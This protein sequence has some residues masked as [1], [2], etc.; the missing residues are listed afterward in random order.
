[1]TALD[2][3][4]I[5]AAQNDD[6]AQNNAAQN[7]AA[8]NN[9]A[10]NNAAQNNAAQNNAAQN[11][12]AEPGVTARQWVRA[13]RETLL[14]SVLVLVSGYL[15]VVVL[16]WCVVGSAPRAELAWPA[17]L[18][19][20]VPGWL[21][22]F[23]IPL[24]IQGA[25]LTALPLLPT[26]LAA[27]LIA[28]AAAKVA[29]RARLRKPEQLLPVIV[30]MG[31]SHAL[32]GLSFALL[33]GTDGSPVRAAPWRAFAHCGAT[34]SLA[35][36]VGTVDRCGV[37]YLLWQRLSRPT[38]LALRAGVLAS[39]L[40]VAAGALVFL[41]AFCASLPEL[42]E[43]SAELGSVGAGLGA[44]LLAVLYVPNAVVGGWS[45]A[46]GAG[47]TMGETTFT[48]FGGAL[49]EPLPVLPL[50]GVLPA[51]PPPGW[52]AGVLAVPALVGVA[53]G[54]HC[55]R[56]TTREDGRMRVLA[57]AT[58]PVA[59][60][61]LSLA[62]LAGGGLGG[63]HGPLGLRPVL[64]ALATVGWVATG[65]GSTVWL[66]GARS[67]ADREQDAV[68]APWADP[69]RS[70]SEERDESAEWDPAE[71]SAEVSEPP[72]GQ[73]PPEDEGPAEADPSEE[74]LLEVEDPD[75]D[76]DVEEVDDAGTPESDEAV[77]VGVRGDDSSTGS[78][79]DP[80]GVA[81]TS[82]A[83]PG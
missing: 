55:T 20:A 75:A 31:L 71:E 18:V 6:A 73:D 8:Q 33:L 5:D 79:A 77:P 2:S 30:V 62:L 66:L 49:P 57:L 42:Q 38:W 7:N 34:A 50:F 43:R 26:A 46:T 23:Q 37:L 53:L 3:A 80:Y 78:G 14:A 83:G 64:A 63:S 51:E 21:A 27:T 35:A 48:P 19:A 11:N 82:E 70:G 41:G 67:P 59:L 36:F 76:R 54:V 40:V 24:H 17:V 69:K 74:E 22:A 29:R 72:E 58:V 10:Q 15:G 13:I 28:W 45:F 39:A 56:G 47:F 61:V 12:A 32:L 68:G 52:L 4:Q 81:A 25:P 65:G 1:M 9:A 16:L 44:S 60:F